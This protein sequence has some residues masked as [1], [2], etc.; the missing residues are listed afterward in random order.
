MK[1]FF[2]T[3][4]PLLMFSGV[5]FAQFDGDPSTK[6][7]ATAEMAQMK[8][9]KGSPELKKLS[10]MLGNYRVK[11]TSQM[12]GKAE[13]MTGTSRTY[14]ATD[15][16]WVVSDELATMGKM[17]MAGH[18]RLSYDANAKVYMGYWFDNFAGVAMVMKG[19]FQGEKFVMNS[20][21]ANGMPPITV[22]MSPAKNGNHMEMT[23]GG[24]PAMSLDYVRV[25]NRKPRRKVRAK[26]K[27]VPPVAGK[28]VA[29]EAKPK[30]GG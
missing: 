6:P 16:A 25:A 19:D 11:G 27:V 14:L 2:F 26:A 20:E 13:R 17:K 18:L 3:A 5:A 28:A 22:T 8:P 29:P 7:A 21:A 4:L 30:I 15:G 12:M 10:W 1:K 24:Q 9:V 23:M